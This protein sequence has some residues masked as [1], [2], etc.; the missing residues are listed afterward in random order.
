[1]LLYVLPLKTRLGVGDLD[2]TLRGL[3]SCGGPGSSTAGAFAST[4]GAFTGRICV[5]SGEAGRTSSGAV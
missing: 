4:T 3:G 5:G 1:M 2:L